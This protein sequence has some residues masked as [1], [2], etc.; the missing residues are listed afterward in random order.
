VLD[1][2]KAVAGLREMCH[3][4]LP[5]VGWQFTLSMAAD[6]LVRLPTLLIDPAP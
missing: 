3:R 6:D 1:W 2:A 5:K 4:V